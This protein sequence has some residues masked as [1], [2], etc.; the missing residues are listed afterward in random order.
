VTYEFSSR[1]HEGDGD[2][3]QNHASP[4]INL[5]LDDFQFM[6]SKLMLQWC[7]WRDG[8]SIVLAR[9]VVQEYPRADVYDEQ[10]D[11]KAAG[12][13]EDLATDTVSDEVAGVC[14]LAVGC[15]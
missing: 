6:F 9:G 12:H 14:E 11:S 3:K 10:H 2:S 15:D 1:S 8:E 5:R 4:W 13:G 7:V